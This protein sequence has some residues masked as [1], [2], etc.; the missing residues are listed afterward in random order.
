MV[1]YG[2]GYVSTGGEQVSMGAGLYVL[3]GFSAHIGKKLITFAKRMR[4]KPPGIMSM[5]AEFI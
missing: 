2:D 1:K 3:S 5:N 4:L